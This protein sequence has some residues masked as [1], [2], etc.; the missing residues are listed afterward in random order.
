MVLSK[1]PKKNDILKTTALMFAHK[2]FRQTSMAEL[3]RS[4]IPAHFTPTQP[5]GLHG[6]HDDVQKNA[7]FQEWMNA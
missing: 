5:W 3:S 1:C 4:I 2:G 6:S 7:N